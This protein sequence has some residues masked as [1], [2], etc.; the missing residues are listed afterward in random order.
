MTAVS[1]LLEGIKVVELG[2]VMS[3]PAAAAILADWGASVIKIEP[4]EGDP[5]RGNINTAYFELDNRGKRSM[6]LDLKSE[7]G[8]TIVRR[9]TDDADVFVSNL[10]TGP[11]RRLG[12]D[13]ESLSASNPRLVY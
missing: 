12:L 13:Y 5:Q 7:A 10:R 9:L 4:P 6:C 11:L 3:G 1:R 2:V 8:R